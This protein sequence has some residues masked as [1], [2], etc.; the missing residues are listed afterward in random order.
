MS[1][2]EYEISIADYAAFLEACKPA[3]AQDSA[4]RAWAA[5]GAKMG[6]KPMTVQAVPGKGR[7]FF[8]AEPAESA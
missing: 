2:R 3:P 5:L 7:R 1:R 8:T 6:F 4:N